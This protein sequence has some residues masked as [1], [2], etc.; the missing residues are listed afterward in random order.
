[1]WNVQKTN[2]KNTSF[3]GGG[4][5]DVQI[6][7]FFLQY[8]KAHFALDAMVSEIL[9]IAGGEGGSALFGTFWCR[10]SQTGD[11]VS[12]DFTP[13]PLKPFLDLHISQ[14]KQFGQFK[15]PLTW[16]IMVWVE[17]F[18][19]LPHLFRRETFLGVSPLRRQFL[20]LLPSVTKPVYDLSLCW[21]N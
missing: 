18:L 9:E 10:S 16:G 20:Q 21:T 19:Q 11:R 2:K 3:E 4:G 6:H 8:I 5:T 17:R 12:L 7:L 15:T 1:M 13:P 14:T